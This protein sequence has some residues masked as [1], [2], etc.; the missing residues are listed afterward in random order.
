MKA[1]GFLG[2]VLVYLN[3]DYDPF[4]SAVQYTAV[5]INTGLVCLPRAV[6]H[7]GERE[8][9]PTE[10]HLRDSSLNTCGLTTKLMFPKTLV[11]TLE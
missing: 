9:C 5:E 4:P 7:Q 11:D 1:V 6:D 8:H 2:T 3:I 10:G